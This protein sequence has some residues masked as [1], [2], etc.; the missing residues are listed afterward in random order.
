MKNDCLPWK[1]LFFDSVENPLGPKDEVME[2]ICRV[3]ISDFT[4][5]LYS[6]RVDGGIN[7]KSAIYRIFYR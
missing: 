3:S 7:V 1:D 4:I 5:S 6:I 2:S